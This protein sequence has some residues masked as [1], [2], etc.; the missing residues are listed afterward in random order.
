MQTKPAIEPPNG[1]GP[2]LATMEAKHVAGLEGILFIHSRPAGQ[3]G[4][5]AMLHLNSNGHQVSFKHLWEPKT[6]KRS[7]AGSLLLFRNS[8][9]SRR[10]ET[11]TSVDYR[12]R[13]VEVYQG[14]N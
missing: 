1:Y 4:R 12:R 14:S 13:R 8:P 2:L 6:E 11:W 10:G 3:P 5:V 7:H 9:N